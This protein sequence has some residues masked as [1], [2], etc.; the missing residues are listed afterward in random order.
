[1]VIAPLAVSASVALSVVFG[2]AAVG[3]LVGR[4]HW[5]DPI[6]IACEVVL[7]IGLAVASRNVGVATAACVFSAVL[8]GA[9]FTHRDV[10]RCQCFGSQLPT[11]SLRGQRIRAMVIMALALL[12]LLGAVT[13]PTTGRGIDPLDSAIGF[14]AGLFV[15]TGP[16][17]VEW[18]SLSESA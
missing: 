7:S 4:T 9:G 11:T 5:Y 18:V 6:A 16:W 13:S 1:L 15:I 10:A 17:L 12:A 3:K 2:V 14:V 8:V